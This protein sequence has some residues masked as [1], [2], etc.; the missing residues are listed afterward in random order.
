MNLDRLKYRY[1]QHTDWHDENSPLEAVYCNAV[2]GC[3][4]TIAVSDFEFC[5][6]LKDK[7][8]TLIYEGDVVEIT[9]FG[10][11]GPNGGYVDSDEIYKGTVVWVRDCFLV[12]TDTD[13]LVFPHSE[14]FTEIIGNV[15]KQAE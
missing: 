3:A 11:I 14:D 6:G 9:I 10:S 4:P 8:G 1:W 15:H 13:M 7:N 5:T 12:K 2:D